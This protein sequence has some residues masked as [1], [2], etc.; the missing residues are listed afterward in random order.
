MPAEHVG[1]TDPR[2]KATLLRVVYLP[3]LGKEQVPLGSKVF[4]QPCTARTRCAGRGIRRRRPFGSGRDDTVC[5]SGWPA[6]PA[7][8]LGRKKVPAWLGVPRGRRARRTDGRFGANADAVSESTFAVESASHL[9]I[10]M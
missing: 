3:E 10:S 5:R 6:G 4:W 2:S 9:E 7:L 1:A 8:T